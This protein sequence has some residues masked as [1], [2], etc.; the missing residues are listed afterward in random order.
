MQIYKNYSL[1]IKT[2]IST[3]IIITPQSYISPLRKVSDFEKSTVIINR[4]KNSAAQSR[5]LCA[6]E[7]KCGRRFAMTLPCG[8]HFAM[9]E[10]R[11]C[12]E[13]GT[14]DEAI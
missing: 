11:L 13:G 9:T 10:P 12:E 7:R 5:R 8:G 1:S 6:A 14:T 3:L 2:L 4:S